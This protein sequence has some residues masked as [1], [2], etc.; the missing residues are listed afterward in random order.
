M[1]RSV[2]TGE[3]VEAVAVHQLPVPV[4]AVC[5]VSHD[6]HL[7]GFQIFSVVQFKLHKNIICI[8][9]KPLS[10]SLLHPQRMFQRP[11]QI[12]HS[13]IGELPLDDQ[14]TPLTMAPS[15]CTVRF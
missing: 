14:N 4:T 9:Y 3:V 13:D 1:P 6:T 12:V 10:S 5:V 2:L 11:H 15:R 8:Y 7:A